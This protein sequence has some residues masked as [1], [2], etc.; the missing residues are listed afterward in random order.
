MEFLF[1][2]VDSFI[3]R[4]Q[5]FEMSDWIQLVIVY[6]L[7]LWIACVI[8]VIRDS[9]A[10]GSSIFFQIFYV[11]TIL[12]LTPLLGL[13]VYFLLRPS[14]QFYMDDYEIADSNELL[15]SGCQHV[16]DSHYSY[17]PYCSIQLMKKCQSCD[18]DIRTD[19]SLC[20]YC[21]KKQEKENVKKNENWDQPPKATPSKK[22]KNTP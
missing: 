17:C 21:W 13:P 16:I 4:I 18:M 20:P 6:I 10:R 12:F 15:C 7:F 19:W 2:I 11:V 14:S 3:S 8:W 5:G 22:T 1:Q 9:S